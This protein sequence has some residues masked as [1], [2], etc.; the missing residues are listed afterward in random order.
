MSPI[1]VLTLLSLQS[2]ARGGSSELEPAVVDALRTAFA[3][4]GVGR[5][6]GGLLWYLRRFWP[7]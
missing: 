1:G 2:A 5:F 3:V 6:L 7:N 4:P